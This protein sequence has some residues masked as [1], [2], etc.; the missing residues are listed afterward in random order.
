MIAASTEKNVEG[1]LTDNEIIVELTNLIFAGT[2]TTSHTFSFMFWEL[3]KNPEWQK[4]LRDE[5]HPLA[6]GEKVVPSYKRISH[7]PILEAVVQ[8]TLRLWPVAQPACQESHRRQEA[9]SMG[10]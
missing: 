9:R 3:A 7:L 6:C 8:E 1:P 2:D 5:L 10:R 4:R